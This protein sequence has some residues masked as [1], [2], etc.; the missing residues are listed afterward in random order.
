MKK[1]IKDDKVIASISFLLEECKDKQEELENMAKKV[2][3]LK[4]TFEDISEQVE[5]I[6]KKLK[7]NEE[8]LSK[9]LKEHHIHME[10]LNKKLNEATKEQR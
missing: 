7:D 3:G 1:T 9:A 5:I 2:G 8:K 10:E 6:D 4:A